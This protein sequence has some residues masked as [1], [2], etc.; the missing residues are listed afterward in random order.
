MLVLSDPD[1]TEP[2]PFNPHVL[3]IRHDGVRVSLA[4][5]LSCMGA[6]QV[7]NGSLSSG[8]GR[9]IT[10]SI[11]EANDKFARENGSEMASFKEY[12]EK[13]T[14]GRQNGVVNFAADEP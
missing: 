8:R 4:D 7:S 13:V 11:S 14:N 5:G 2:D 12:S 6:N 1:T 10:T 9:K 3:G